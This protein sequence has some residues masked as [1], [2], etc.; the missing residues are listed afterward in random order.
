MNGGEEYRL[1]SD[2]KKCKMANR[3][4]VMVQVL[5]FNKLNRK[6]VKTVL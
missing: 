6:V 3:Q 4:C 5:F 1:A 2:I